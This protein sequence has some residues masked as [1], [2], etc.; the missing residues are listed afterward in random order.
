MKRILLILALVMG[1]MGV[2]GQESVKV[3]TKDGKVISGQFVNGSEELLTIKT[4]DQYVINKYGND[5]ISFRLEDLKEVYMYNQAFVPHEGTLVVKKSLGSISKPKPIVT[6]EVEYISKGEKKVV[7]SSTPQHPNYAIG[8]ALK[9]TG[10][11]AIGVGVPC[12]LAGTILT[13]VGASATKVDLGNRYMS[14]KE[15]IDKILEIGNKKTSKGRML[16]AGCV[17]LPIG[18][19]L[20]I[21]GIP[22]HVHGKKIM[23]MNFNYTGNGVGVGVEF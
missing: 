2:M 18:A 5:T 4:S 3:T 21:V 13:A 17:L 9:S 14:D 20:T 16:T 12:L 15:L 8:K 10:G 7:Y 6:Q 1:A 23:T 19:S 11:V 22:L